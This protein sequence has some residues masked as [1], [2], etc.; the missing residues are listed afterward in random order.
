M[1]SSGW[2]CDLRGGVVLTPKYKL[3]AATLS[4]QPTSAVEVALKSA[5]RMEGG[6]LGLVCCLTTPH[7]LQGRG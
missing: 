4:G 2:V 1:L 7:K 6:E 3:L 5:A